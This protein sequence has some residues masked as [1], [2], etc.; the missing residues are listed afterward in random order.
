MLRWVKTH[1]A[2]REMRVFYL[3]VI[4]CV[5]WAIADFEG[6]KGAVLTTFKQLIAG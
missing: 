2:G 4:A 1:E 5:V 6:F 3:G